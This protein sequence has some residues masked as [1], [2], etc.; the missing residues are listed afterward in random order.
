MA[1]LAV[2]RDT[3][4]LGGKEYRRGD[5]IDHDESNSE[6]GNLLRSG[7]LAPAKNIDEKLARDRAAGDMAGKIELNRAEAESVI[8]GA[9][10]AEDASDADE[11]SESDKSPKSK[12]AKK[13]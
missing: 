5:Q 6:H 9:V 12:T 11:A 2:N 7:K 1:K 3:L 4:N 10:K 8:T 13:K